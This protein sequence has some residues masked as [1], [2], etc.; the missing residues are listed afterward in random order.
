MY[1]AISSAAKGSS[2]T[3]MQCKGVVI[4]IKFNGQYAKG[5]QAETRKGILVAKS[6][7]NDH[8]KSTF[9]P[10]F[11]PFIVHTSSFILL[12]ILP[13]PDPLW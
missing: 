4:G 13:I 5:N 1:S 8:F 6:P 12:S 11:P 7:L 10:H 2:S 3:I 9:N